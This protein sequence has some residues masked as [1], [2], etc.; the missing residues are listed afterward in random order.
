MRG[1]E[2]VDICGGNAAFQA[3]Y[4]LYQR[5]WKLKNETNIRYK[6]K[7]PC[8]QHFIFLQLEIRIILYWKSNSFLNSGKNCCILF[9]FGCD[10]RYFLVT[11]Q[12]FCLKV[13]IHKNQ[14]HSELPK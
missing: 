10:N 13:T 14:I 5:I 4:L 12:N 7:N 11:L 9:V 6:D 8:Y 1:D 2:K 3:Y